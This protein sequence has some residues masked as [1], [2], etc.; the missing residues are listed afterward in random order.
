MKHKFPIL[1]SIK[2]LKNTVFDIKT[3][4]SILIETSNTFT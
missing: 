2:K 3:H 1:N 4:C